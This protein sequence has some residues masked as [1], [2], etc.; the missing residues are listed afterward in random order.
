MTI[1]YK[2]GKIYKLINP[3]YTNKCYVGSTCKSLSERLSKHKNEWTRYLETGEKYISSYEIIRPSIEDNDIHYDCDPFDDVEIVL[4]EKYS[5]ET[6]QELRKRERYHIE[7]HDTCNIDIPTR[8]DK[9]YREDNK[10]RIKILQKQYR[11]THQE[12]IVKYRE[13]YYTKNSDKVKQK[14][15]EY[16][17]QNKDKVLAKITG[18]THHCDIC[19]E[20][21]S[22][23]GWRNHQL[24]KKHLSKIGQ[25]SQDKEKVYCS[26]CDTYVLKYGY[27]K[28]LN[29]RLHLEKEGKDTSHIHS[30]DKSFCKA[31]G[32][33]VQNL[34][35]HQTTKQ[36]LKNTGQSEE[37]YTPDK[38]HCDVCNM[39]VLK[40]N[41]PQ[42][43]KTK[44]HLSN[45][46]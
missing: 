45:L 42:H 19:N 18:I 34:K 16:Y 40:G 3:T 29:T 7:R 15:N 23:G 35:R 33:S 14:A 8:T 26:I 22:S 27:T 6:K 9:E 5:C 43:L 24:T 36:H 17:A 30:P 41:Y 25:T 39:D 28:H 37:N 11:E 44:R 21:I 13:E 31:C 38:V 12:Q 4:I 10:E 2:N 32:I 20:D 46:N 1:N